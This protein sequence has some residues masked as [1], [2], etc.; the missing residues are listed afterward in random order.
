[1]KGDIWLEPMPKKPTCKHCR[2]AKVLLKNFT[3]AIEHI[4]DRQTLIDVEL[5]MLA[6]L[7]KAFVQEDI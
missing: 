1:V 7:T 6:K 2:D 3:S 5:Q 4:H